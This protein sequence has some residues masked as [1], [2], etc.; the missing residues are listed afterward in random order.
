ME[1]GDGND[2]KVSAKKRGMKWR[3]TWVTQRKVA[4]LTAARRGVGWMD[5]DV[6]IEPNAKV[7][8]RRKG[9]KIEACEKKI[10]AR[11]SQIKP[12]KQRVLNFTVYGALLDRCFQNTK[13]QSTAIF[14]CHWF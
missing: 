13:L 4:T 3:I 1:V 14:D 9:V 2:I 5:E 6:K 12:S 7:G 10:C 8:T 11:P